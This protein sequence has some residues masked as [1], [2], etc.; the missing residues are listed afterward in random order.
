[1]TV[2]TAWD[3]NGADVEVI[4]PSPDV[5]RASFRDPDDDVALHH[6]V[7]RHVSGGGVRPLIQAR[8]EITPT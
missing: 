5:E 4:E 2:R 6:R 8:R 3:T 7:R 1:V